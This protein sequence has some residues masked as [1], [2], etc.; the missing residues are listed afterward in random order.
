MLQ[1][2]STTEGA[3]NLVQGA[4]QAGRY[5]DHYRQQGRIRPFLIALILMVINQG[6]NTRLA[7]AVCTKVE[8]E[9]LSSSR[10]RRAHQESEI[11]KCLRRIHG[12]ALA[13]VRLYSL[14]PM[15]R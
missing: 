8:I 9:A 14:F 4:R 7:D 12:L 6:I 5:K 10:D 13:T 11:P 15:L 3:S 2:E 1:Y